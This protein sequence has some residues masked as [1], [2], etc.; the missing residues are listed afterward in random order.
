M[1][2]GDDRLPVWNHTKWDYFDMKS[3]RMI[4]GT[5]N[6]IFILAGKNMTE[7]LHQV[8][9]LVFVFA[10]V[11]LCLYYSTLENPFLIL[12]FLISLR[13]TEIWE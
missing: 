6:T 9:C 1:L 8:W 7:M 10:C 2:E 13:L 4:T 5:L 12:S 3:N 11:K